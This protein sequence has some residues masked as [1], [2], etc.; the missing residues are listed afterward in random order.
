MIQWKQLFGFYA[1]LEHE[2]YSAYS[3]DGNHLLN[4][5]QPEEPDE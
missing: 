2:H 4:E 3:L 1:D 5:D